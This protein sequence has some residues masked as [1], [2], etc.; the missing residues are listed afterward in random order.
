MLRARDNIF[1]DTPYKTDFL[2]KP[3][4]FEDFGWSNK[5][6]LKERVEA[7]DEVYIAAYPYFNVNGM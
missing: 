4:G 1:K 6:K 7:T 3:T 2:S 5:V